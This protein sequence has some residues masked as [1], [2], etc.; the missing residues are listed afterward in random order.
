MRGFSKPILY[1]LFAGLCTLLN[2][3]T[4]KLVDACLHPAG[5]RQEL[6]VVL[7]MLA[8]TAV[9]LVSKFILDK[10]IVFRQRGGTAPQ[11]AGRFAL[12]SVF[13]AV[14]TAIFWGTELLFVR[15]WDAEAARYVGGALGLTAGYTLKFILD[16]R[17][18]F[19]D[20]KSSARP[21]A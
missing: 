21:E 7:G 16:S 13:G 12:Y 15:F 17:F 4:Q 20:A 19:S 6:V 14:T 3:G 8:G 5:V 2:L 10:L 11:I 9:G 1:G 18:V